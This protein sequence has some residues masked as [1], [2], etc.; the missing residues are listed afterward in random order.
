MTRNAPESSLLRL[1]S[2]RGLSISILRWEAEVKEGPREEE[3][4]GKEERE[5]CSEQLLARDWASLCSWSQL[6][7]SE[8]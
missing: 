4:E 2:A 3:I 1:K 6:G 8:V 5:G 7:S